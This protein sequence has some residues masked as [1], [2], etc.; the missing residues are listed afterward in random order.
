MTGTGFLLTAGLVVWWW[1]ELVA[2]SIR[3]G[4]DEF[5]RNVT[6]IV[7]RSHTPGGSAQAPRRAGP[8]P[9]PGSRAGGARAV[10]AAAVPPAPSNLAGAESPGPALAGLHAV[11]R[12]G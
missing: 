6:A 11:G 4:E 5:V 10:R 7:L 3:R 8:Q 1:F 9:T 12:R 2:W